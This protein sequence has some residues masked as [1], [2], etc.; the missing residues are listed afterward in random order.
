M[1]NWMRALRV[2]VLL[3]ISGSQPASAQPRPIE[4]YGPLELI[5]V[6]E[7]LNKFRLEAIR[8]TRL[9]RS[10]L[11]RRLFSY[12]DAVSKAIPENTPDENRWYEQANTRGD[13]YS[14]DFAV[15]MRYF[16]SKQYARGSLAFTFG[17]CTRYSQ[18][19]VRLVSAHPLEPVLWTHLAMLFSDMK[20]YE[21]YAR[22]VQLQKKY[23]AKHDIWSDPYG[24]GFLPSEVRRYLHIAIIESLGYTTLSASAFFP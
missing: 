13:A 22:R 5:P 24:I 14:S 6:A 21:Q 3:A 1:F 15:V 17:E 9:D 10:G 2:A 12:C 23:D 11:A 19:L 20:D 18:K 8:Q 4:S 16:E 7:E